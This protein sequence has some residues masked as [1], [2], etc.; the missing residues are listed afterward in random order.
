MCLFLQMLSKCPTYPKNLQYASQKYPS[1]PQSSVPRN[2]PNAAQPVAHNVATRM[3]NLESV[4]CNAL[5]FLTST[6]GNFVEFIY[7]LS[8]HREIGRGRLSVPW[9]PPSWP[10]K[11]AFSDDYATEYVLIH[12]P[13]VHD[14]LIYLVEVATSCA[15]SASV[16]DEP[17]HALATT[18]HLPVMSIEVCFGS[19]CAAQPDKQRR[20]V[21][22]ALQRDAQRLNAVVD[23]H[24]IL[25]RAHG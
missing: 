13:V 22:P 19:H 21:A 15:H 8:M 2:Y 6:E 11:A 9:N 25:Q 7:R 23:M 12:S 14:P 17:C 16:D 24:S 10:N 1:N 3:T 4:Q 5:A 18:N 20:H